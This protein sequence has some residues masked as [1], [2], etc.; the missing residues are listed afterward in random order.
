MYLALGVLMM[1]PLGGYLYFLNGCRFVEF[2]KDTGILIGSLIIL[3]FFA[4]GV[5]LICKQLY[6]WINYG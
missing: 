6:L 3:I 1:L 2:V 5:I 4:I